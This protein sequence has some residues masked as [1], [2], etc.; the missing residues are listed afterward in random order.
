MWSTASLEVPCKI[1]TLGISVT[2]D[3]TGWLG[4]FQT[5]VDASLA[6]LAQVCSAAE[7]Q[8][9]ADNLGSHKFGIT[10][11]VLA[12][13]PQLGENAAERASRACFLAAIGKF[14]SFLDK[15]IA[16]QRTTK[17]GVAIT[18]DIAGKAE[19]FTPI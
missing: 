3:L 14:I 18:R 15:L 2:V 5:E 9:Y 10:R 13:A 11:L 4:R 19:K 8:T 16:S 7:R 6:D 1:I 17:E 12:H